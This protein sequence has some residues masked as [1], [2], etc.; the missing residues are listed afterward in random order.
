M[1]Y[2]LNGC[3]QDIIRALYFAHRWY[4]CDTC[5]G[6][7]ILPT[8]DEQYDRDGN[9]VAVIV[10]GTEPCMCCFTYGHHYDYEYCRN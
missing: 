2:S 5:R 1:V 3:C 8:T 6:T 4:P 9:L 7:G 10:T